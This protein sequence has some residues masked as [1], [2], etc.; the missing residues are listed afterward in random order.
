MCFKTFE[1]KKKNDSKLLNNKRLAQQDAVKRIVNMENDSK[2][3]K[4]MMQI[5]MNKLFDTLQSSLNKLI[6]FKSKSDYSDLSSTQSQDMANDISTIIEN[7]AFAADLALF[8]PNRFHK[9]FD[10]R[11]DF[12]VILLP[13]TFWLLLWTFFFN[14]DTWPPAD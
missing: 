5:L 9:L 1:N 10:K 14:P 8:I 11:N 4:E 7:T 2:K 13:I 3:Q 6:K 12:L